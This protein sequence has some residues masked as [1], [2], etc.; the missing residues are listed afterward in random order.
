MKYTKVASCISLEL[1]RFVRDSCPTEAE[2]LAWLGPEQQGRY[3]VLRKAG[4]VLVQDGTVVLSPQL[5]SP[6]GEHLTWENLRY[7]ID[8]ETI[9]TFRLQDAETPS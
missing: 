1:L 6:D 8:E 9:D 7:N 2:L 3:Y 5:L 4:V